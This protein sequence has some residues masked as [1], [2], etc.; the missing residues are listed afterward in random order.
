MN[1][2]N[3]KYQESTQT[4]I[5]DPFPK[6]QTMPS[7]WDLSDFSSTSMLGASQSLPAVTES[8]PSAES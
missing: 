1:T 3:K 7:G 6:P 2:P 8:D 5:F 4:P